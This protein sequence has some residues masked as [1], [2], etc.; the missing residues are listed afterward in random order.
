MPTPKEENKIISRDLRF[1]IILDTCCLAFTKGTTIKEKAENVKNKFLKK[2]NLEI[3]FCIP[4]VVKIELQKFFWNQVLETYKKY[5]DS[6][7]KLK[8]LLD[9]TFSAKSKPNKKEV[10][11]IVVKTLNL[12]DFRIL[13]NRDKIEPDCLLD[14]ACW[15]KPP[16]NVPSEKNSRT[17]GI[18]DY[19]IF[20]TIEYE[21]TA[22]KDDNKELIFVTADNIF[23]EAIETNIKDITV[24]TSI[25]EAASFVN[26]RHKNNSKLFAKT[27]I[28]NADKQ[29]DRILENPKN[30]IAIELLTQIRKYFDGPNISGLGLS[31][32]YSSWHPVT[33]E[34]NFYKSDPIIKQIEDENKY[35]WKSVF[36]CSQEL[37]ATSRPKTGGYGYIEDPQPFTPRVKYQVDLPV[38]WKSTIDKK[39]NL[40]NVKLLKTGKPEI[41]SKYIWPQDEMDKSFPDTDSTASGQPLEEIPKLNLSTHLRN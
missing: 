10:L 27:I 2:K 28:N 1:S 32:A 14:E 41:I 3:E 19:F 5:D 37:E 22:N 20:K 38:F 23:K 40:Y 13:I 24:E 25:D 8:N 18:E 15:K 7:T 36:R 33:G 34:Y 39:G 16:F 26:V 29:I 17:I 9:K 21:A 6:A 4:E 31:A 12:L 11:E 35:I 30:E